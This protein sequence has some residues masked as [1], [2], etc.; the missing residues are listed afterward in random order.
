MVWD[1]RVLALLKIFHV[2]LAVAWAGA[3]LVVQIVV[4]P[5][6]NQSTPATRREFVGRLTPSLVRYGNYAG[7]LTLLSGLVLLHGELGVRE[8]T[9]GNF[10][11]DAWGKFIAFGI[12][13][14]LL[15]LYLVNV[16]VAPTWRA[17]EK[18]LREL[19]P[20]RAVPPNLV[21]LQKRM[22]FAGHLALFLILLVLVTMVVAN[23]QYG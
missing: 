6:L 12:L 3:G 14:T 1:A 4:M 22:S 18:L 20:D 7:G 21:F 5:L 16:A 19:P 15:A 17:I 10:Y 8:L 13:V 9:W 23:S 11:A 2:L